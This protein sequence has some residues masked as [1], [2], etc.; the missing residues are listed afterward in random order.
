MSLKKLA[1]QTAI[2]GGSSIIGRLLNYMILT[3]LFTYI[4]ND[5]LASYGILTELYSYLVFL[6][7]IL[8]YGME[9]AF[10]RYSKLENPQKVYSNAL[11]SLFFTSSI[12]VLLI[13]FQLD[14]IADFLDYS[15]N[16]EYIM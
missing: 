9:T 3:P 6:L 16:P 13:F 7:V 2:Y 15:A 10:F 12:F 14:N 5:D 8:T 1:G 11:I 4:F